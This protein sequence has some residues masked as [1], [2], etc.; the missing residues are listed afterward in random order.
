MYTKIRI[1]QL[2]TVIIYIKTSSKVNKFLTGGILFL[3]ILLLNQL[4]GFM[5]YSP[6]FLLYFK[7]NPHLV[8]R[9]A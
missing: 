5:N 2:H 9:P 1:S 8:R 7:I 3:I 6:I 4:D